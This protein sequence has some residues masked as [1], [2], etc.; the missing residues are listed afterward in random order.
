M[1]VNHPLG[2]EAMLNAAQLTAILPAMGPYLFDPLNRTTEVVMG[3]T[4]R[5][6]LSI[7]CKPCL[8]SQPG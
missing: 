2:M 8:R 6:P 4:E 1:V 5:I 3:D 7:L